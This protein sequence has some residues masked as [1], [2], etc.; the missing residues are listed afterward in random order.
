MG[1]NGGRPHQPAPSVLEI[2]RPCPSVQ[3]GLCSSLGAR[4]A[5]ALNH[6]AVAPSGAL[7]SG[8]AFCPKPKVYTH[9]EVVA[10]VVGLHRHVNE[11]AGCVIKLWRGG[12]EGGEGGTGRGGRGIQTP[13]APLAST[14]HAGG[15][16]TSRCQARLLQSRASVGTP[17][18]HGSSKQLHH[19]I[20]HPPSKRAAAHLVAGREV[21]PPARDE[22][23]VDELKAVLHLCARHI[24]EDGHHA[25][26]G[27]LLQV[28]GRERRGDHKEGG[29]G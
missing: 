21:C 23:A 4:N 13:P 17:L 22:Q 11:H 2:V 28:F 25:R 5:T 15:S 6:A 3:G 20:L 14:S 29:G 19:H 10:L 12:R 26:A 24:V 9:G 16:R 8:E 18:Q 7:A 27:G 1:C